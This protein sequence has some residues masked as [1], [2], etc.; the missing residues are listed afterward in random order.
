MAASRAMR[1]LIGIILCSVAPAWL[2]LSVLQSRLLESGV[3][4]KK[5]MP[6]F[7]GNETGTVSECLLNVWHWDGVLLLLAVAALPCLAFGVLLLRSGR[8]HTAHEN[9]P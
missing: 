7:V 5:D 6:P 4:N 1:K 3:L 9:A 8:V 2:V